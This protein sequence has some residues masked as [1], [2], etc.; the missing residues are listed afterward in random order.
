L[1]KFA[2][3]LGATRWHTVIQAGIKSKERTL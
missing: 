1:D 2:N 3:K